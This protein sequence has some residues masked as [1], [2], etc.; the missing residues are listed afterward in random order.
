M[1]VQYAE[2]GSAMGYPYY[3]AKG[4]TE[5]FLERCATY[6]LPNGTVTAL[7]EDVRQQFAD[8]SREVTVPRV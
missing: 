2:R 3:Y 5:V 1:A 4:A 6:Y 7:T 8:T